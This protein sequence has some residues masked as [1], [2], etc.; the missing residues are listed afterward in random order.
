MSNPKILILSL[1]TTEEPLGAMYLSSALKAAGFTVKGLLIKKENVVKAFEKYAPDIV[2]FSVITGEHQACLALN[3]KLKERR[4]FIS[5]FGGWYTTFSQEMINQKDIDIIGIGEC[6][7]AIVELIS[8]IADNKSLTKVNNF[9]IKEQNKVYKN[10]VRPFNSNLDSLAFPDRSLFAR[11]E[12][13][14]EYCVMTSR[15]CPYNCTYCSNRPLRELY[16]GKGRSVRLRSVANII[17]EVREFKEKRNAKIINFHDDIFILDVKRLREFSRRFKEE[18]DLPFI[19]SVKADLVTEEITALLKEAGCKKV[20]MGVEAGN[21]HVRS[22]LLERNITKPQMLGARN[23]FKKYNI[24]VFTQ[25]II[26]FPDTT[27]DN[28]F[29]TMEFNIKLQPDFSWV[30]IFAPY[31]KTVLGELCLNN[32]LIEGFDDV[33]ST[34]HY[35]SP[36]QLPHREQINVL[37]KIFSLTVN[38]PDLLP[39]VKDLVL[40]PEQ[41]NFEKLH[42]IF[43]LYRQY[44]YKQVLGLQLELPDKVKDFIKK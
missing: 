25:N 23:L 29:E 16:A 11:S 24:T 22:H 9:L 20:F 35:K 13:N 15:G 5:V 12:E 19:C 18:I 3:K 27:I 17:E 8:K 10:E 6:E 44:K 38:Y 34:Y 2:L 7:E 36:L 42:E 39:R 32:R 37:H 33:Y 40:N 41:C 26:G 21:D 28:D 31:P 1:A 30:S 4:E 43:F 14:K